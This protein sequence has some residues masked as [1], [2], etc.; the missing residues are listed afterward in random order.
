MRYD[1]RGVTGPC[2]GS[3]DY[4]LAQLLADAGR[5]LNAAQRDP[6]VDAHRTFVYG[7][8]EGSTQWPPRSC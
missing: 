1:K 3:T 8:S 2:K 5:V 7:W 4:T 6:H